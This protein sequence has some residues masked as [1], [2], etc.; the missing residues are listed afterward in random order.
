MHSFP[1]SSIMAKQDVFFLSLW[2]YYSGRIVHM[3]VN[4]SH[5]REIDGKAVLPI[6]RIDHLQCRKARVEDF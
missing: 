6:K 5:F 4:P 2:Q 1:T 3:P